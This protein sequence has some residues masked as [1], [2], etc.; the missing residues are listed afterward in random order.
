MIDIPDDPDLRALVLKVMDGVAEMETVR[1]EVEQFADT[2]IDPTL[3]MEE[4]KP[5]PLLTPSDLEEDDFYQFN[6]PFG[7]RK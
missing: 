3:G 6:N 7:P 4:E 5:P 1:L 2:P